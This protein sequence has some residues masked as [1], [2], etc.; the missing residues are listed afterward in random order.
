MAKI[1]RIAPAFF[2]L[3]AL[4]ACGGGDWPWDWSGQ[5]RQPRD[6]TPPIVVLTALGAVGKPVFTSNEPKG[7]PRPDACAKFPSFPARFEVNA[8]NA[9]GVALVAIRVGFGRIAR[10]SI[11]VG[12]AAAQSS[13]R[14][15]SDDSGD[16]LTV[17]LTP[18]RVDTLPT[19]AIVAFDANGGGSPPEFSVAASARNYEGNAT[20]LYPVG[21][22]EA[23]S[24]AVCR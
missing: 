24:P 22:R 4:S 12:A 16:T 3:A 18:L 15:D 10:E 14:L 1:K 21:A 6:L 9:T 5:A 20:E 23:A 8:S 2:L 19:G 11:S 13:W 7:R 17:R